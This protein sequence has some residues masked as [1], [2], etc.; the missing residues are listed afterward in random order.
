MLLRH[1]SEGLG[2]LHLV[3]YFLTRLTLS[4]QNGVA[5]M[6]VLGAIGYFRNF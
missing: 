5:V 1:Y 2:K 3:S 6:A 4:L